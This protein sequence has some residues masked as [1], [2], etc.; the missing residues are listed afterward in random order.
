MAHM[1]K[2]FLPKLRRYYSKILLRVAALRNHTHFRMLE[3]D[4]C[5]RKSQNI[6]LVLES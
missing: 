2:T 5:K 6:Q 1:V 4:L 3:L